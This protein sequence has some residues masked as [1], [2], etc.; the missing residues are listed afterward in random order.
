MPLLALNL[1]I[2]PNLQAD[3]FHFG[4]GPLAEAE[5]GDESGHFHFGPGPDLADDDGEGGFHFGPGP[6]RT[7]HTAIE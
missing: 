1:A 2:F 6:G 7:K 4:P 5:E 3:E